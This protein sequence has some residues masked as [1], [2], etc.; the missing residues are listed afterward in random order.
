MQTKFNVVITSVHTV[1]VNL[2]K[3]GDTVIPAGKEV[4]LYNASIDTINYLRNTFTGTGVSI[5]VGKKSAKPCLTYDYEDINQKTVADHIEDTVETKHMT[6][7]EK[8]ANFELPSGKHQGEKLK[9][10]DD[11]VLRAILRVSKTPVVKSAISAYLNL[12]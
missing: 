2:P 10:I 11:D 4:Q 7:L 9:D 6:P 8:V 1:Q 5:A 3:L 12:K